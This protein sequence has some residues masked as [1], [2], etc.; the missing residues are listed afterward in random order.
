MSK[1]PCGHDVH[2]A[3][4]LFCFGYN[5]KRNSCAELESIL[6]DCRLRQAHILTPTI[7]EFLEGFFLLVGEVLFEFL[8]MPC[9][10][11]KEFLHLW[12]VCSAVLLRY[13]VSVPQFVYHIFH[14]LVLLFCQHN[15]IPHKCEINLGYHPDDATYN[16]NSYVSIRYVGNTIFSYTLITDNEK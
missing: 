8:V 6:K 12:R 15:N 13:D 7:V 5:R 11:A 10:V 1:K 3:K 2:T 9:H 4:V 16:Y 14:A